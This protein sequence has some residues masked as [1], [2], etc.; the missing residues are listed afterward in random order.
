MSIQEYDFIVIGSGPAGEKGAAQAAYFGKKVA[1]VERDSY[2]GGAAASATIPSKTLRETSLALSGIR[3]RRLH[4]VDLSLRRRTMVQ[5]FLHHEEVMKDIERKRVSENMLRHNVD[6][7]QGIGSFEDGHTVKVTS[8]GKAPVFLKGEIVLIATGSSPRWPDNF[9][10]SPHIFDSD[11][12]LMIKELPKK[13]VIVGGGVIG[14]EYACTFAAL[15]IEVLLLHG[16]DILLPFIDSDISLALENSMLKMSINLK[17]PVTVKKCT[18]RVKGVVIEV[19]SGEIIKT[20]TVMLATGRTSNTNELNL[21]TAGIV[22]GKRGLLVVNENYQVMNPETHEPVPGI[23]AAGDAIGPPALASTSMEQ[24]RFA[25]IKAFNLDPY[26]DHVAPILPYGVYTIPECSGVGKTEE[27]CVSE[28]ID[29]I[30]G[31]ASYN[32]NARGMITGDQDGFLKLHFQFNDDPQVSMK[33]LGVHM[34]GENATE[35]IHTGLVALMMGASHELFI[36]TCF[37]YPTLSE[38]YKYATYD[39][40]GKRAKRL[41]QD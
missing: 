12:I 36:N 8:R 20:D 27:Q 31:K 37:N 26:K 1:M 6:I 18:A 22:P 7:Y 4:G 9:P 34:I 32:K 38:L 15:G 11:T 33:L 21:K 16:R 39:A 5:D 35:L 40:M 2:L 41:N 10:K 30:T 14:C 3:S 17:M 13:M 25:T 28:G 24:A 23:Y 19:D 29:Y